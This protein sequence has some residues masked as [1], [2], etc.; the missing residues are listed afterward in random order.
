MD[1]DYLPTFSSI[2]IELNFHKIKDLSEKFVY[3]NDDTFI[4][5]P[6]K[7]EDFFKKGLPCDAAILSALI[8]SVKNE[9]IT[10]ILFNDLLLIN[11]NFSKRS[12]LKGKFFKWINLK[13]GKK[14]IKNLYYLPQG[15][16]SGFANPHLPNSFLKSTFNEVWKKEGDILDKVCRNKFRTNGDVNQY[17]M[18]YWQ[19]C[20]GN[21]YP[22][23]P[24]IGGGFVLGSDND[25]ICKHLKAHDLKLMCINDNPNMDNI[26][27]EM[28]R[29]NAEFSVIFPDKSEF[30]L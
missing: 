25:V 24:K 1:K 23:S 4:T 17:L 14:A 28:E 8:P 9:I 18:S 10:Y 26:E 19:L 15:K 21:F 16:F 3:F 29:L 13:Y 12:A 7:E 6:V 11:A 27:E 22:R 2:P 20:S 5:A 30:E